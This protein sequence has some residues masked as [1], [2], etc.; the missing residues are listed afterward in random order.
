MRPAP[1]T[2]SLKTFLILALPDEHPFWTA[3][4]QELPETGEISVQEQAHL[5]FC[6]ISRPAMWPRSIRAIR[7]RTSIR[8]LPP[9]TRSLFTQ[10]PLHSAFRG[11]NGDWPRGLRFY[12]GA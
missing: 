8:I 6:R 5:V 3:E 10:P 4:E 2:E 11:R 12:A 1:C 7:L 9:S